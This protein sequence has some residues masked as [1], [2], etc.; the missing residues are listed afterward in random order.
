MPLGQQQSWVGFQ[1]SETVKMLQLHQQ[2]ML[3]TQG[4]RDVTLER[5]KTWALGIAGSLNAEQSC[6]KPNANAIPLKNL[7]QL[8]QDCKQS[9]G[10]E[11]TVGAIC[12]CLF[13]MPCFV[14]GQI[15][16]LIPIGLNL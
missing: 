1:V 6:K 5:T 12:F 10:L 11:R 4:G 3:Q 16:Y 14:F 2:I 8:Q 7:V 9:Q 13:K 15:S